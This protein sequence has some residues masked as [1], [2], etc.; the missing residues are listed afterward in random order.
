[1]FANDTP[2]QSL[3]TEPPRHYELISQLFLFSNVKKIKEN[4][5]FRK[6]KTSL[7]P[8]I[9]KDEEVISKLNHIDT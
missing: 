1:M 4:I 5:D 8:I 6:T 9:M 2:I 7:L 3:K